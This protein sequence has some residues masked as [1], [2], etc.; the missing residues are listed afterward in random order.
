LSISK[1]RIEVF[2][3]M[4]AHPDFQAKQ[5]DLLQR[6]NGV[7]GE[8]SVEDRFAIVDRVNA[9]LDRRL[10]RATADYEGMLAVRA[11]MMTARCYSVDELIRAGLV[12]KTAR[13]FKLN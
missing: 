11:L 1:E 5:D 2:A 7:I 9:I 13:S 10:D 3:R 6:I 8:F 12:T 4:I